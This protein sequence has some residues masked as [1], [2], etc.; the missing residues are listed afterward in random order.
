MSARGLR[1]RSRVLLVVV[2]AIVALLVAGGLATAV[3]L[4]AN[5]TVLDVSD[6]L[7]DPDAQA[8]QTRPGSEDDGADGQAVVVAASEPVEPEPV[9]ILVM[10][11]DT[12]EGQGDGYG[13]AALI[14]G[15][16]SD[17]TMLVHLSGDRQHVTVLSIPRDLVVTLPSCT[18]ADG[19]QSYPYQ[20]R[21]NAAFSIGGPE[22]TIRTVTELTGLPVHHFVV[23]DFTAFTR[24]I[25]AL[26]GVEVCLTRPV[27]DPR[28][29]LDLPAGVSRVDGA[30]GLAFVRARTSLG[31]G[32]D[33]ARIERQQAFLASL[34]REATSRDLLT[35]PVRL[36]RSLDA[37][38]QSLTMD[39]DLAWLPRSAGLA[40]SLAG[41]DPADVS[42]VTY[43]NVYSDDFVTV[44]PDTG[45]A[46]LVTEA[47]AHDVTWPFPVSASRVAVDPSDVA[48][49]V[50]NATGRG[51]QATIAG[52]ALTR[53]GFV[54]TGLVVGQQQRRTEVRHPGSATRSA[55]SVAAAVDGAVLVRDDT[56]GGV[57]LVLGT[58]WGVDDVR[59]VRV[60][61]AAAD[62]GADSSG[63]TIPS[64]GT[65]WVVP[66]DSGP[67]GTT[68]TADQAT[69]AS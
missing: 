60:R 9:N 66:E 17:T 37:A 63:A 35:D 24:T 45:P 36:V 4:R 32:S 30:Q 52:A 41:V 1:R 29:G 38:T 42:F 67:T 25:D 33:L 44:R 62:A 15:A 53:Q 40:R 6:A 47:L 13:S 18:M 21:F 3:K 8:L 12:R 5:I 61:R 10:G 22:C 57:T 68:S 59:T 20:D 26:G 46:L 2:S 31:D 43:P 55:R 14:E 65:D 64:G 16:R 27:K 49:R 48:V 28:A 51:D 56:V 69:C 58:R 34:V 7:A 11:S 50:V 54:V 19:S 39:A 23:V